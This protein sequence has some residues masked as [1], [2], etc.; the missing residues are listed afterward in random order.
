VSLPELSPPDDL[1]ATDARIPGLTVRAALATVG[2]LLT[3]VVYGGSG[4][5]AVGVIFSLLSA[6]APEYLLSWVVVVFLALGELSRP[7]GLSWQ[8]LVL[9]AGVHLLHLLGMLALTLPWRS[10]LQPRLFER[11]LRRFIA[12]QIP[13]QL[14]AVAT[15]LLF[16][17]N[18]HGHRPLTVAEFTVIGAAALAGLTLLLLR[19]RADEG[20]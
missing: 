1:P 17:P 11:P 4:W 16:A 8:L 20:S 13:A 19:R 2:I 7:A 9:I 12:I 15:L 5:V 6:W 14:L 10:W 3:L 18:A